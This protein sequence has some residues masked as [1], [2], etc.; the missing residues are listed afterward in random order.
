MIMKS[1]YCRLWIDNCQT[2]RSSTGVELRFTPSKSLEPFGLQASTHTLT[3][4]AHVFMQGDSWFNPKEF[5]PPSGRGHAPHY[6]SRRRP[7]SSGPTSEA[8]HLMPG[9]L[10]VVI[11]DPHSGRII[12]T[13]AIPASQ[14]TLFWGFRIFAALEAKRAAQRRQ[15]EALNRRFHLDNADEFINAILSRE[16]QR[17]GGK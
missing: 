14:D 17:L 2:I 16:R 15:L 5:I 8:M 7:G 11:F 1:C 13:A 12:G 6:P 10:Q 3:W 4:L 9:S